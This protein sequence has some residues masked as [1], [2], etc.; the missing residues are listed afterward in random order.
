MNSRVGSKFRGL[1][2]MM[3]NCRSRETR[4]VHYGEI[5]TVRLQDHI[6]EESPEA[7][8]RNISYTIHMVE[9]L[10]KGNTE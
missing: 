4:K 5:M 8:L 6:L 10:V 9:Y 7:H 3:S 1:E 2:E